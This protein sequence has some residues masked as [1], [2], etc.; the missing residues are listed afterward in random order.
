MQDFKFYPGDTVTLYS[1]KKDQA[2]Q[3]RVT[4]VLD[5][6]LNLSCINSGTEGMIGQ[7]KWQSCDSQKILFGDTYN[8]LRRTRLR[9]EILELRQ[10][11]AQQQYNMDFG[12][13]PDDDEDGNRR[14]HGGGRGQG[15]AG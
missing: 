11:K 3:W 13:D 14:G 8:R 15:A 9:Q 2:E 10:A 1:R 4:L 7:M 6:I 5:E 12:D